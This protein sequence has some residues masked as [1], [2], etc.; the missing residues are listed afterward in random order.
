M[1]K[2]LLD[3]ARDS[4]N[5]IKAALPA[6]SIPASR[7]EIIFDQP[8]PG[9]HRIKVRLVEDPAKPG[10]ILVKEAK[11]NLAP[12]PGSGEVPEVE[13]WQKRFDAVSPDGAFGWLAPD[14]LNSPKSNDEIVSIVKG[15]L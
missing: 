5:Q 9:I 2:T 11:P 1:A 3:Q 6:S 7:S 15:M 13:P 10:L 8:A 4:F 14:D 12:D